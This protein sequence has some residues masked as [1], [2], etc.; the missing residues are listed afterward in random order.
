MARHLRRSDARTVR[1]RPLHLQR[2][3]SRDRGRVLPLASQAK[4]LDERQLI[5]H[6]HHRYGDHRRGGTP[7]SR[8]PRRSDDQLTRRKE[9]RLT[10]RT[11]TSRDTAGTRGGMLLKN[12]GPIVL[13]NDTTID[14]VTFFL[15]QLGNLWRITAFY[16]LPFQTALVHDLYLYRDLRH[17]DVL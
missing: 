17:R 6:G 14:P 10:Q 1:H 16:V 3:R 15:S 7:P 2:L 4:T 8:S 12:R 13:K 9:R 11:S 5:G